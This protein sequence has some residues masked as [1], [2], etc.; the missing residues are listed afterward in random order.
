MSFDIC[1]SVFDN[2]D[3]YLLPVARIREAFEKHIG[4][5]Y[6]DG[7]WRLVFDEGP[8]LAE[9]DISTDAMID[10]E[11]MVGGFVVSRPPGYL[12]FWEIIAGLLRDLPCV[13]YWGGG[14][15]MGSLDMLQH[16]PKSF[17]EA[18][19]IPLVSIDPERIRQ[20]VRDNS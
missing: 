11:A 14:A 12:A 8:S 9:V 18:A 19:G 4:S 7:L 15:V 2:E 16:L 10:G 1:I 20:H 3:S 5:D 17:V 6:G 13:L